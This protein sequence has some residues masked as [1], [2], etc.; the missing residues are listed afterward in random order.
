MFITIIITAYNAE[1]TIINTLKSIQQQTYTHFEVIIIDDGSTDNTQSL[2]NKFIE[3]NKLH[4]FKL[5]PLD[6]VGRVRA[7]NYGCQKAQYDWIAIIDADDLWHRQK[8]AIQ[9]DYI[10]KN[11]LECVATDFVIFKNDEDVDLAN[12]ISAEALQHIACNEITLNHMLRY[13]PVPHSAVLLKKELVH[14][15]INDLQEDWGLWIRLLHKN[16]KIHMIKC[17]LLFH[18]IHDKQSFEYNKHF[19]YVL[20][21][22]GLQ[23][24]Y[25]L[26]TRK[27]YNIPYVLLRLFYHLILNR[28]TR[29]ALVKFRF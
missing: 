15:D 29:L 25:C 2:V 21:S 17:N 22:C 20:S 24:K 7:L 18:R 14:Y 1:N 28:K 5:I 9:I 19:R 6:H 11:Q 13:N 8:L 3:E 27:I 12:P 16:I 26:I 23:L 4:H 10:K